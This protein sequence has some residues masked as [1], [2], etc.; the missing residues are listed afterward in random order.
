MAWTL[1]VCVSA[2]WLAGCGRR[3][4][5]IADPVAGV[6]LRQQRAID[7]AELGFKWPFDV[8]TGTIACDGGALFFRSGGTTYALTGGAGAR[9]YPNVDALRR[10]QGSGPPSDPVR[11][12]TQDVRMRLFAQVS[13][14]A[15]PGE[16]ADSPRA[17]ECRTRT[18]ERSGVSESELARIEAEGEERNWPPRPPVLMP[19]EPLVDAARQ[20]CPR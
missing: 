6:P 19:V 7:R 11:R 14:C 4:D 10:V 8:G 1:V 16:T 18:R 17:R 5:T 2:A 12:L 15:G 13:A 3:A 9:G 20:L